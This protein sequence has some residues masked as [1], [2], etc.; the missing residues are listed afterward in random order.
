M[1]QKIFSIFVKEDFVTTS[2]IFFCLLLY[3]VF[4]TDNVFQQIVSSTTFLLVIPILYVK[5]ILKKNLGDIG[6]KKG[7]WQ[8][9]IIWSAIS[10]IISTLIAYIL[11]S[12]LGLAQRYALPHYI[13][14]SFTFFLFY[15]IMLF[16]FFTF[17]YEVFFR[18]FLMLNFSKKIGLWA[19]LLQALVFLALFFFTR[20]IHW[21]LTPYIIFLI[22]SGI[23][24]YLSQSIFYSFATFLIF[25]IIFDSFYIYLIK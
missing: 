5:I 8:T 11:L 22:F 3:A 14:N 18:G 16:G 12:Y 20:G 1:K 7:N 4:P 2:I 23:T 19:I 25:N 10:L 15:E 21:T 9:G 13:A 17:L 6:I 24:A